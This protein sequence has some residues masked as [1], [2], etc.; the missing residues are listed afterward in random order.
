MTM[1]RFRQAPRQGHLDRLKRIFAYLNNYNDSCITFNTE[2]PDYSHIKIEKPEWK[3]IYD[4]C[5]EEIPP[6]IPITKEK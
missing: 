5:S 3:Y 2:E 6:Y 1:S 4:E